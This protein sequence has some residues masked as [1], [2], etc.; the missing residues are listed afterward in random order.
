MMKNIHGAQVG[1]IWR[2]QNGDSFLL[3]EYRESASTHDEDTFY[4]LCIEGGYH[5]L[6]YFDHNVKSKN[7]KKVA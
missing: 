3:L 1:D 5:D 4:A 6:V 7:W 2:L